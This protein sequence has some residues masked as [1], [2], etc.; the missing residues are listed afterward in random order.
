VSWLL[1]TYRLPAD[2]SSARVAV[3]REVRR[4]GALQLQQSVVAFPDTEEFRRALARVRAVV[5]DVGG[6]AIAVS[7]ES[8]EPDDGERLLS[9]WND[10]RAAEYAELTAESE[11]LVAEI[12][13]EFAKEKFTLAELDEEEAELEKLQRWHE[14][15]RAR[16]VHGCDA[17][18]HAEAALGHAAEALARY[19]AAVFERT[20]A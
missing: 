8:L 16:D 11:K 20:H 12:D 13:K 3:W 9:A 17:A 1:L 14:R 10:A 6:S 4:S 2:R 19:T 7:A 18:A 5:A 15:I